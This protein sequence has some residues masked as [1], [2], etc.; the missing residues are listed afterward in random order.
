M[1]LLINVHSLLAESRMHL[2]LPVTRT[3]THMKMYG[4]RV[5]H[6]AYRR[7]LSS[8]VGLIQRQNDFSKCERVIPHPSCTPQK[9]AAA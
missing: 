1:S 9:G 3:T 5:R 4:R 8:P 7:L 2:R 6:P